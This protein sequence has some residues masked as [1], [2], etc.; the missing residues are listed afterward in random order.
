[1][2][3]VAIVE[4]EASAANV[5]SHHLG[6][7]A[8]E[9]G[10]SIQINIYNSAESFLTDTKKSY[11]ILFL[12]IELS[13]MNGMEAAVRVREVDKQVIIIFVT[14]MAQYAVKGYEVDALYYIIKPVNYQ[15]VAFK[16]TKALSILKQN[17]DMDI[18]LTQQYGL[19]RLSTR[20]VIYVEI[21][22]HKLSY[23]TQDTTHITYGSLSSA[24]NELK[25]HGF[26]RCNSCYLVNARYIARV[27]G[28]SVILTDGTQLQ[29]S[30]P[31]KKQFMAELTNWLSMGNT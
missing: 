11:D 9:N 27:S 3:N 19:V 2:V 31:R 12:D 14:N 20:D 10:L 7:F 16:L 1:M 30:H 4:D 24:E 6:V 21:V 13:G 25:D 26:V 29:I 22:S 5:L 17:K 15:N 18:V 23:H 28:H 8:Q